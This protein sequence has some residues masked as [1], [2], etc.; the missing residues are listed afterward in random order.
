M[1]SKLY[2][3]V[4]KRIVLSTADLTDMNLSPPVDVKQDVD[5]LIGLGRT[6]INMSP[7]LNLTLYLVR[8]TNSLRA[9]LAMT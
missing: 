1:N 8:G 4:V 5:I 6:Q 9:F 3:M 2:I 7:G